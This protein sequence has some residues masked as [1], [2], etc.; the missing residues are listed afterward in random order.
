ML[1]QSVSPTPQA[2]ELE[3]QLDA[4]RDLYSK[5]TGAV[6]SDPAQMSSKDLKTLI[7][8][9]GLAFDDCVEKSDFVARAKEAQKALQEDGASTGPTAAAA[10]DEPELT[11]ELERPK[12]IEYVDE[13]GW[14][15]LSPPKKKEPEPEPEEDSPPPQDESSFKIPQL[16]EWKSRRNK[17]AESLSRYQKSGQVGSFVRDKTHNFS[18]EIEEGYLNPE[19]EQE[20]RRNPRT[21]RNRAARFQGTEL[22]RAAARE[23]ARRSMRG[24]SVS[25]PPAEEPIAMGSEETV[26][27]VRPT[28]LSGP[29]LEKWNALDKDGNGTLDENEVLELANFVWESTHPDGPSCGLSQRLKLAAELM[30]SCD[31]NGDGRL[32]SSEFIKFYE[33]KICNTSDGVFVNTSSP[34]QGNTSDGVFVNTSTPA[35]GQ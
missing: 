10:P 15:I 29:A 25:E 26:E 28:E 9:A 14:P 4:K 31:A 7:T 19:T 20:G 18:S 32:D 23:N 35:Q 27:A 11:P 33:A 24:D 21:R 2:D 1:A 17:L 30:Q 12:K 8:S 6:H 5:M 22:E 34:A 16:E 3:K 13:D